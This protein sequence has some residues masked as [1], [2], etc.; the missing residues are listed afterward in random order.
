MNVDVIVVIDIQRKLGPFF[1]TDEARILHINRPGECLVTEVTKFVDDD[2]KHNIEK[3]D[4]DEQ[5]E[6]QVQHCAGPPMRYVPL[7]VVWVQR[8]PNT[9]TIAHP[10]VET[11][12]KAK[13][14]RLTDQMVV[15]KVFVEKLEDK[16]GKQEYAGKDQ[17]SCRH[18]FRSGFPYTFQHCLG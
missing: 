2:T 17:N 12:Q 11:L 8:V 4:V 7:E 13:Q 18:Q 10:V 1:T 3:D 16:N 15:R 9:S 6:G 14:E 5:K